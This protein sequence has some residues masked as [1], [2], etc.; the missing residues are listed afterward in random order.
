MAPR[1]TTRCAKHYMVGRQ[2]NPFPSRAAPIDGGGCK[3][4]AHVP[5]AQGLKRRG[6]GRSGTVQHRRRQRGTT[7]RR[8]AYYSKTIMIDLHMSA[9]LLHAYISGVRLKTCGSVVFRLSTRSQLRTSSRSTPGTRW[10]SSAIIIH[11]TGLKMNFSTPRSTPRTAGKH[12]GCYV[13]RSKSR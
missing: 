4:G 13:L 3:V 12:Q 2:L 10:W 6:R 11:W 8:S 9:C 1:S 7:N 5:K